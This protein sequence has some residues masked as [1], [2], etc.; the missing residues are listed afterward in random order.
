MELH[1]GTHLIELEIAGRPLHL[2]LL[3][4]D[5]QAMLVDCGTRLHAMTEIPANLTKLGV[6]VDHLKW[7]VITHGDADHCGG[8]EEMARA[9][10]GLSIGCGAAEREMIQRRDTLLARR[11]NALER[12]HAIAA[13]EISA[14]SRD[15]LSDCPSVLRTFSGGETLHLGD[16]RALEIWHLP[17]HSDGHVGVYDRKYRTLFCG[18]A[19]Q[20]S[21]YR[22]KGGA[23]ALCPIYT[24]VDSYLHTIRR[25]EQADV[26]V[27]VGCHWPVR[28]GRE[29]IQAFCAETRGFVET[30]ESLVEEHVASHP[31][32]ATLREVC[33]AI[34][35]RLGGW[36]TGTNIKLAFALFSHLQRAVS[37]GRVMVDGSTRPVV[38]R[39]APRC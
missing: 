23:W 27:V 32:G 30:A 6:L 25:V 2:P 38:F 16:E 26:D 18:D 33:T 24:N 8:V 28:R 3:V 37:Q 5:D 9:Y 15:W 29:E 12:D 11:Y 21:G 36:P 1:A 22:S 19:L 4:E 13:T 35:S 20:G 10:R 7:L 34:G 14:A 39:S 17:G 31:A